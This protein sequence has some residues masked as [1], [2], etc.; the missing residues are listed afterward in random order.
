MVAIQLSGRVVGD[1]FTKQTDESLHESTSRELLK[2]KCN[3]NCD[4]MA[5]SRLV[6]LRGSE[7]E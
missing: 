3:N 6:I 1:M 2:F 5:E 7:L 4:V